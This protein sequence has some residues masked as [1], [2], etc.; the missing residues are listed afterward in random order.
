MVGALPHVGTK[1]RARIQHQRIH[2]FVVV[3]EHQGGL[4]R[5]G[6]LELVGRSGVLEQE[7]LHSQA[8]RFP[9]DGKYGF[10]STEHKIWLAAKL[11]DIPMRLGEPHEQPMSVY[12]RTHPKAA[13]P[14]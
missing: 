1:D 13:G 5:R 3:Y 8:R 7:H 4:R 11:I 12:L 9:E 14:F 6:Q 2:R 10:R